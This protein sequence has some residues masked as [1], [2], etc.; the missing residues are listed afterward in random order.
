MIVGS[1]YC[2]FLNDTVDPSDS[3]IIVSDLPLKLLFF[4]ILINL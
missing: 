4:I 1:P 3:T 2:L